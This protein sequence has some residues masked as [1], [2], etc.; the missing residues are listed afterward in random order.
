[1]KAVPPARAVLLVVAQLAGGCLAALLAKTVYPNKADVANSLGSNTTHAEG[2]FIESF[3]TFLLIFTILFLAVEKHRATFLAPVGIGAALFIGHM[4]SIPFT[5][6]GMNPARTFGPAVVKRKFTGDH[7]IYWAGPLTGA[8]V[9]VLFY[10][11]FKF[12]EYE[13]TNPG[14]DGDPDNDPT[15]DHELLIAQRMGSSEL[16]ERKLGHKRNKSTGSEYQDMPRPSLSRRTDLE[17]QW[18]R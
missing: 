2:Y 7:W 8:V 6:A 10:K 18:A 17:A 5:G 16:R 11:V 14:Q 15:Q 12:L 9:A 3:T 13:M 4:I 1:M